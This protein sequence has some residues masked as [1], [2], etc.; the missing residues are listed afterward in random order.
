M[1]SENNMT[2]NGEGEKHELESIKFKTKKKVGGIK[3]MP[4]ILGEFR[5]FDV[6]S[7]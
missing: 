2:E 5:G 6:Q 1:V 3:A 4:F 7:T